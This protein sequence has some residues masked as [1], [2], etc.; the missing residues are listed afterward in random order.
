MAS[1]TSIA[2]VI[3]RMN[4]YRLFA[5]PIDAALKRGWKVECWHDVGTPLPMRPL[6]EPRV[7][8]VP[9][10]RS[11]RPVIREFRGHEELNE[12]IRGH[13][14][15][16][17]IDIL[18]AHESNADIQ[19]GKRSLCVCME[20]DCS[21]SYYIR[22]DR[23]VAA[24]DLFALTTPFW[25]EQA[26]VIM[27]EYQNTPYSLALEQS[28]REKVRFT[29]WPQI[30]QLALI[31]PSEV[32][33]RLGIPHEQPVVVYL[34]WVDARSVNSRLALF[35]AATTKDK[36]RALIRYP[37]QF[38][39]WYHSLLS[40]NLAQV[41][42]VIS[43]FCRH[44]D[45][46]LLIK[47]RHRDHVWPC[48]QKVADREIGDESYYPH[49]ILEVM[50]IASLC[51][52]YFSFGV[53]EAVGVG[54][55]Y[56]TVD[57]AGLADYPSWGETGVSMY[58]RWSGPNGFFNYPGVVWKQTGLEILRDLSRQSLS[59]FSLDARQRESYFR[60]YLGTTNEPNSKVFLDEVATLIGRYK[61]T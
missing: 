43:R 31:K 7:E 6:D 32:R 55:P 22:N 45:A 10:Y 53:R 11:G 37:R 34:N 41:V 9:T 1:V 40:P 33:M 21:W 30:D 38:W 27:R 13:K 26:L 51:I 57:V 17:V 59:D 4:W 28:I 5:A 24:T 35:S 20:G 48:E 36:M 39:I 23:N 8:K 58:R 60:R 47:K 19:P 61:M 2:F 56:L 3:W 16:A 25:F 49:S 52:G 50:S 29:G 12:M 15:D 14:V 42:G 44:N 46:F 54:V 18:A